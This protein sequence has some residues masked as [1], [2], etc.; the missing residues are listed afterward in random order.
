MNFEVFGRKHISV[1]QRGKDQIL[2][3]CSGESVE[4]E[5][6]V[7]AGKLNSECKTL[8][9]LV[10]PKIFR[11]EWLKEFL[12]GRQVPILEGEKCEEQETFP[13]AVRCSFYIE[14][15]EIVFLSLRYVSYI[16]KRQLMG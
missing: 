9:E 1:V 6:K 16:W 15:G 12:D 4:N 8:V 3:R 5:K 7:F 14:D 2:A 13:R 10:G 11:P